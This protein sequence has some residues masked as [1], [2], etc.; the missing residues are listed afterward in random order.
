VPLIHL[1][2]GVA[3]DTGSRTA[4]GQARTRAGYR[5]GLFIN[6]FLAPDDARSIVEQP[7]KVAIE[8]PTWTSLP[9]LIH[10][11]IHSYCGQL[12]ITGSGRNDM[13]GTA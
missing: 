6:H 10:R 7:A 2:C 4:P 8:M 5:N 1:Y 11:V 12:A 9:Q 13:T 3:A